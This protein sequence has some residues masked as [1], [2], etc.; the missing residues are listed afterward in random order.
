MDTL[1]SRVLNRERKYFWRSKYMRIFSF[2]M[3]INCK[4]L[5]LQIFL[6]KFGIFLAKI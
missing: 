3:K 4:I 2:L 6:E 5:L 1:F